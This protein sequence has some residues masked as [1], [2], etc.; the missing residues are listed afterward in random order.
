[1]IS[2][3]TAIGIAIGYENSKSYP[4]YGWYVYDNSIS[5]KP[6]IRFYSSITETFKVFTEPYVSQTFNWKKQAKY[7]SV[8][9]RSKSNE[10]A[11][12]VNMGLMYLL[13]NRISIEME[14][15]GLYYRHTSLESAKTSYF[16]FIYNPFSPN[17]G[18]KYYF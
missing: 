6:H 18:L 3:K 7:G 4:G 14:I 17:I 10:T 5:I 15:L 16:S 1:M 8:E 2:P 12:G 9:Y 13:T 11:L